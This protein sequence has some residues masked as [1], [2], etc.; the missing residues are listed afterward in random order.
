M[1]HDDDELQRGLDGRRRL[2]VLATW[3]E[4]NDRDLTNRGRWLNTPWQ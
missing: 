1:P 3:L 4:T 2:A